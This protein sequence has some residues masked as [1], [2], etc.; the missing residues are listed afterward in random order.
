LATDTFGA[1]NGASSLTGL[2]VNYNLSKTTMV[3]GRYQKASNVVALVGTASA[4]A[5][6][7]A[8]GAQTITAAG[9]LVKF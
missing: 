2:G 6:N 9:L 5:V 4:T 3:Y 7:S 1:P 8:Y